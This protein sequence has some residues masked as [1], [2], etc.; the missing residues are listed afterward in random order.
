MFLTIMNKI[1][2]ISPFTVSYLRVLLFVLCTVGVEI[3]IYFRTKIYDAFQGMQLSFIV[4]K[5]LKQNN[6]S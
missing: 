6:S 4:S 2:F 1:F 3:E 5:S